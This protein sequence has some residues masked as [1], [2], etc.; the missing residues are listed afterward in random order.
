MV[1]WFIL[2]YLVANGNNSTTIYVLSILTFAQGGMY[3]GLIGAVGGVIGKGILA[4][5]ITK[6]FSKRKKFPKEKVNGSNFV[7]VLMGLGIGLIVYNFL[8]GNA[9]LENALIGVVLF[10]VMVRK[11]K[12]TKGFWYSF[13][14]TFSKKITKGTVKSI[15]TGG[16]LGLLAGVI[17]SC[18]KIQANYLPYIIGAIII[19]VSILLKVIKKPKTV[20]GIIAILLLFMININVNAV[21]VPSTGGYNGFSVDIKL[22]GDGAKI[23]EKSK[24]L[25]QSES[26]IYE[27]FEAEC[28]SGELTIEV[29]INFIPGESG[30]VETRGTVIYRSDS[31]R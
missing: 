22:I 14:P 17:I 23:N 5:G 20:T 3:G 19:V 29:T 6:L 16:S 24:V 7:L 2:S 18:I 26:S 11:T 10:F 15:L 1:V 13:L 30:Y 9:S 4:A 28:S 21:T 8:S 12:E 27:T 31:K 25:E